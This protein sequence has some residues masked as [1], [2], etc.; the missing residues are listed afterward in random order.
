ME[1]E[2]SSQDKEAGL[3]FPVNLSRNNQAA[4]YTPSY[5]DETVVGEKD[6]LKVDMGVQIDGYITDSAFTLDFSGEYGKM[7]EANE[8]ALEN[9]IAMIKPDIEINKISEEIEKTVKSFGFKP[10][11]NLSGH[12]LDQYTQHAPPSV[13]N[14]SNRNSGKF[15]EGMVFAVE[16]FVSNGEG[17]IRE[18]SFA[19][20]F[21]L[22]N[23]RQLRNMDSRK[24][25][26]YV[27]ENFQTLPFAER[28]LRKGLNMSDFKFKLL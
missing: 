8:K 11:Q 23:P 7:I 13:P 15:E 24:M 28:Q 1:K 5:N 27:L 21:M 19:E 20:I 25:I 10:V 6:V 26:E 22:E 18:G 2:A 4:H 14:V 16:P 9:A 3:A 17:I 12:G